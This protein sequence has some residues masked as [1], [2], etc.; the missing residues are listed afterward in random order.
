MAM[1]GGAMISLASD[2]LVLGRQSQLGPI[3]PQFVIENKTHFSQSDS[4]RIQ[5]RLHEDSVNDDE[6]GR[7]LGAHFAKYGTSECYR[8]Q[9]KPATYSRSISGD[10]P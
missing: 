10:L 2:L 5:H 4:R 3:D 1:S 7:S 8:K 6:G 9:G